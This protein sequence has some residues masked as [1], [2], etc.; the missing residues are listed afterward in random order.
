MQFKLPSKMLLPL[1][2][3]SITRNN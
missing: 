3:R 1:I 2:I